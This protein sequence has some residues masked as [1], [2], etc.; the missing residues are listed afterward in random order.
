MFIKILFGLF[1]LSAVLM[2]IA[3]IFDNFYTKEESDDIKILLFENQIRSAGLMISRFPVVTSLAIGALQMLMMPLYALEYYFPVNQW[4]SVLFLNPMLMYDKKFCTSVG[5]DER[6][7]RI[8]M[9][10]AIDLAGLVAG[11]PS[12]SRPYRYVWGGVFKSVLNRLIPN[13][14]RNVDVGSR[15]VAHTLGN[16]TRDDKTA[17]SKYMSTLCKEK[18]EGAEKYEDYGVLA[19]ALAV[20]L[21]VAQKSVHHYHENM[22]DENLNELVEQIKQ[23]TQDECSGEHKSIPI[24]QWLKLGYCGYR[25]LL[26][27]RPLGMLSVCLKAIN[28]A[29]GYFVS[30]LQWGPEVS[31]SGQDNEM[32]KSKENIAY[33]LRR[34]RNIS[35]SPFLPNVYSSFSWLTSCITAGMCQLPL[36]HEIQISANQL[37]N[38]HYLLQD[39]CDEE[40][41]AFSSVVSRV[42]DEVK[43]GGHVLSHEVW[44]SCSGGEWRN[45]LLFIIKILPVDRALEPLRAQ[46]EDWDSVVIEDVNRSA[47]RE[48]LVDVIDNSISAKENLLNIEG[49][50]NKDDIDAFLRG[51]LLEL[52][53]GLNVVKDTPPSQHIA[54]CRNVV[55]LVDKILTFCDGGGLQSKNQR[56]LVHLLS[57]VLCDKEL[58]NDQDHTV[59]KVTTPQGAMAISYAERGWHRME[60]VSA[61]S[62]SGDANQMNQEHTTDVAEGDM[63]GFEVV[64]LERDAAVSGSEATTV[65]EGAAANPGDNFV[66]LNQELAMASSND[67]GADNEGGRWFSSGFFRSQGPSMP[68]AF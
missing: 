44:E 32:V 20:F 45:A 61:E 59:E 4:I 26:D 15:A 13:I 22:S 48:L 17:L 60:A 42:I 35:P 55:M 47:V 53:E 54:L 24:S 19:P 57:G 30:L 52:Q 31:S 38:M 37:Q 3:Y 50:I 58:I 62:I 16:M 1:I 27:G 34:I 10:N 49:R 8:L 29:M 9:Q 7:W 23:V 41:E 25:V 63:G 14:Q 39:V 33:L 68:L 46:E 66:L 36:Q 67:S 28:S 5:S 12:L 56:I 6:F 2:L 65:S 40:I 51:V 11:N 18:D 21:G 43:R 64:D